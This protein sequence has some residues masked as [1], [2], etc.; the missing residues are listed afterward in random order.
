MRLHSALI[1]LCLAIILLTACEITTETMNIED[2]NKLLTGK[3]NVT[4]FE[5]LNEYNYEEINFYYYNTSNGIMRV[6]KKNEQFTYIIFCR[7]KG[8]YFGTVYKNK[9][10]NNII[11]INYKFACDFG[12]S[13]I[14]LSFPNKMKYKKEEKSEFLLYIYNLN[15][16]PTNYKIDIN[17]YADETPVGLLETIKEE[18]SK[19]HHLPGKMEKPVIIQIPPLNPPKNIY[20]VKFTLIDADTNENKSTKSTF[21][22]IVD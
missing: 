5:Q 4:F 21:F 18:E 22:S 10:V 17:F 7:D 11:K 3:F 1:I 14:I 6:T 16:Y 12:T 13:P 9:S 15:D 8:A 2:A 19:I 20:P